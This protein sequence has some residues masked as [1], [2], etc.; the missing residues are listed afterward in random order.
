MKNRNGESTRRIR[1]PDTRSRSDASEAARLSVEDVC[2]TTES[3]TVY[4]VFADTG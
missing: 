3:L 4:F 2:R 1:I